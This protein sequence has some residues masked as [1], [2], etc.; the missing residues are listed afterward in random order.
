[1]WHAAFNRALTAEVAGDFAAASAGYR[2]AQGL[3]GAP[4]ERAR[5]LVGAANCARHAGDR[6]RNLALLLEAADV[7]PAWPQTFFLLSAHHVRGNALEEAVR[8]LYEGLGRAMALDAVDAAD[9]WEAYQAVPGGTPRT[10]R[11]GAASL[12][13]QLYA[14]SP[15]PAHVR[16]LHEAEAAT[17][18]AGAYVGDAGTGVCFVSEHLRAGSVAAV[19]LPVLRELAKRMGGELHLWSLARCEDD[20]TAQFAGVPGVRFW[21]ERPPPMALAVCLDGHTGTGAALRQLSV[22][23]A[24]VQADW[25]GYPHTTGSAAVD[26]K[27][28]DP[29]ADPPGAEADY[30][31][32]LYRLAPCMWA[33]EAPAPLG[34]VHNYPAGPARRVLVCQ[35][36][37]KVRPG[38][39]AAV[40]QVLLDHPAATVHF[41]CTLR[42]DAADV[43][44]TWILPRLAAAP[45]RV[46]HVPAAPADA[47]ALDL[48]TYHLALDTWP[49]SGTVTTMEC[50]HAGLPVVTCRQGHHRGR[51]TASLLTAAGLADLVADGPEAFCAAA[52]RVLALPDAGMRDLHA[53]VA[54]GFAGSTVARP[55]VV[56]DALADMARSLT[57]TKAAGT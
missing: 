2:H 7:C 23:L 45:G 42:A 33:W 52:G 12:L 1:M 22:R 35:N 30:T 8:C 20:V 56:A 17:S 25:L 37:K 54:A 3:A 28:G 55:G 47:L 38:F 31:E 57:A 27:V 40:S 9:F 44:D 14:E 43:F 21:R 49:Y 41:R 5:A 16:L 10:R 53:R 50:L 48:S 24:P 15:S 4:E 32:A 46:H 39:L 13:D 36:F 11:Y 19:F 29:V 26:V 6:V 51:A 18:A 34:S